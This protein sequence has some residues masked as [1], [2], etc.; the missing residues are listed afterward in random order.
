[1]HSKCTYEMHPW[2]SFELKLVTIWVVVGHIIRAIN[3]L[4]KKV[5]D[6]V[7]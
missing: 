3:M 1:M 5:T 2:T 7:L 6:H 4:F